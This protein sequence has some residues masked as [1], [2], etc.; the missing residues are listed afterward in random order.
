MPSLVASSPVRNTGGA[1]CELSTAF[2]AAERG[3]AV[4]YASRESRQRFCEERN[5]NLT[6]SNANDLVS[7][8]FSLPGQ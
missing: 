4:E 8:D 5:T 1:L 7:T 3:F 2:G 6:D